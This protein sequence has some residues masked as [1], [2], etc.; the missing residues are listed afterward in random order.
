MD[1]FTDY[2]YLGNSI[3]SAHR[4]YIIQYLFK[5]SQEIN[6]RLLA[7]SAYQWDKYYH[8]I[9]LFCLIEISCLAKICNFFYHKESFSG[10]HLHKRTYAYQYKIQIHEFKN[11]TKKA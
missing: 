6:I 3:I 2:F 4:Q 1:T 11:S 5:G 10:E 7:L 9:L 8:L